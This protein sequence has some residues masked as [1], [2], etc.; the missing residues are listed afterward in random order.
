MAEKQI[1]TELEAKAHSFYSEF[2]GILVESGLPFLLGGTFAVKFYTGINR[3]SKDIDIFC[4]AGDYLRILKVFQDKGYRIKV[5]DDRWLAKVYKQRLYADIIFGSIPGLWP[6]TDSWFATAQKGEVLG[7]K[8]L[9][10]APEELIVSKLYRQGRDQYDGADVVHLILKKGDA[11][12]WKHLL[13]RVEPHWEVLLAQLIMYRFI[14]P[15]DRRQIPKWVMQELLE[16]IQLQLEMPEPQERVSKGSILSHRD[17]QIAYTDWG[18][19]DITD[20]FYKENPFDQ[21]P[22]K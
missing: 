11:L 7:H 10:P 2:L 9:I 3:P 16:R 14:Y 12:D 8:V 18:Y 1:T 19:K 22:L 13:D 20:F 6:I 4:K 21:K 17:Y 5:L 15:S